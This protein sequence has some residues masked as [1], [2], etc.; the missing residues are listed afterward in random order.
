MQSRPASSSSR[1]TAFRL[2]CR[3]ARS[4]RTW[5]CRL[6]A[7]RSIG[8]SSP[9]SR[10]R[11]RVAAAVKRLQ[12]DARAGS[13]VRR[14]SGGNQQKVVIARWV[15]AGFQTLLCFDPTSG[16]DVGTKHQIYRLLREMADSGIGGAAVYFRAAGNRRLC[17]TGRS[18]CSAAKSSRK[19]RPPMRTKA[20]CFAQ[21]MGSGSPAELAPRVARPPPRKQALRPEQTAR[22]AAPGPIVSQGRR[23]SPGT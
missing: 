14:L 1:R 10:E 18:S 8:A 13:E 7:T 16:I 12:I 23:G 22:G 19:W 17:A 5:L 3:S 15:A 11:E 20:P 21:R 6:S 2:S 4:A 9:A